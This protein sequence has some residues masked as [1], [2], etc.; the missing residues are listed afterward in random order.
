MENGPV[1][2]D[3]PTKGDDVSWPSSYTRGY[4]GGLED[5]NDVC[6]FWDRSF[7]F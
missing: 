2:V 6:T 4:T 7:I 3:I 5:E 1:I